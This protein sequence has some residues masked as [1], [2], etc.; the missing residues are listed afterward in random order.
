M[1]AYGERNMNDTDRFRN[2]IEHMIHWCRSWIDMSSRDWIVHRVDAWLQTIHGNRNP[3]VE[4]C[5]S[6]YGNLD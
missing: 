2:Y 4:L 1:V 6:T 5:P 3:E